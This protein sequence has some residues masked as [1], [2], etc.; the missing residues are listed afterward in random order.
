[1][2]DVKHTNKSSRSS[3]R[4][5][6]IFCVV[7]FAAVILSLGYRLFTLIQ[8]SRFDGQHSFLVAFIYKNDVDVVSIS[9]DQKSY[10]HLQIRGGKSSHEDLQEVAVIPDST[11][12]LAQPFDLSRLSTYFFKAAWHQEGITTPLNIYDLYRLGLQTESI[13]KDTI[14][15]ESIHIP[16]DQSSAASLLQELFV[17]NT[18]DQENKTV[19]I[20]N[21]TGVPGLGSR[22][23]QALTPIGVH[24]ISVT[25]SNI[26]S[27]SKIT[28]YGE[29]SYTLKHISQLLQMPVVTTSMQGIS[30]IIILLGRDRSQTDQF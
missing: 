19:A 30:D 11:I 26:A 2:R 8:G 18:I 20:I 25:N 3:L 29:K 12:T 17:D 7:V 16:F 23:E 13:A 27:T 4:L 14:V 1:M 28:Y 6:V 21:G 24:V 15:S 10:S 22:L 5:L 9:P